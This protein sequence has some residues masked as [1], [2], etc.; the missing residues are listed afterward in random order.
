MTKTIYKYPLEDR[1]NVIE[2]PANAVPLSVG[3]QGDKLML[4]ALV[5]TRNLD[6]D[7]KFHVYGTGW[8]I[9]PYE[10]LGAF[11]GTIQCHNG[12]VYH[13]FEGVI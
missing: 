7:R 3:Q 9:E 1:T 13:V 2:M 6:R 5:D 8:P 4:W 11:V 12:L 10:R